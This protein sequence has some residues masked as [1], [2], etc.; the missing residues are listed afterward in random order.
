MKNEQGS[1]L[2]TVLLISL[3]FVTIGLTIATMTISSTKQ[4]EIRR[5]DASTSQQSTDEINRVIADFTDSVS[6]LSLPDMSKADYETKLQT[7]VSGLEVKYTTTGSP[8]TVLTITDVTQ[9]KLGI[10]N[11]QDYYTRYYTFRMQYV[12]NVNSAQPTITNTSTRTM[13]LSPTP[14]FLQ[15]AVGSENTL[16]LNGASDITGNIYGS[17]VTLANAARYANQLT[18]TDQTTPNYTLLETL[19]PSVVGTVVVDNEIDVYNNTTKQDG[20]PSAVLN[21]QSL[22]T[23]P[24]SQ[25]AKYFYEKSTPPLLQKSNGHF[26]TVDF[27]KT[28]ADKLNQLG[29][30]LSMTKSDIPLITATDAEIQQKRNTIVQKILATNAPTL[31]TIDSSKNRNDLFST[32]VLQGKKVV[33]LTNSSQPSGTNTYT[34]ESNL[35]LGADQWLVVDGNLELS[36]SQ[37]PLTIQGNIL[38]LGNIMIHGNTVSFS[39]TTDTMAF[40]TT[41]YA[42]GKATI[43]STN[44]VGSNNKMLVLLA[45]DDLLITRINEL[46]DATN[47]VPTMDG[48]FYTDNNAELYGVG[49]LFHIRG[50]IFAKN[51]LTINAIRQNSFGSFTSTSTAVNVPFDSRTAQIGQLSRFVVTYDKSVLVNNVN[52]LPFATKLSVISDDEGTQTKGTGQ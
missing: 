41:I 4:A 18:T 27:P 45:Q 29:I 40:A 13:L 51:E 47:S 11:P 22:S 17:K 44:I 31:Y 1:T 21:K 16:N 35:T 30:G 3:L 33:L 49:S 46:T 19:Y 20:L 7:I 24:V 8:Q 9:S 2:L 52:A 15:Y 10:S 37:S 32:G 23:T 5:I 48:Y 6:K 50:G 42:T 34:I 28:V 36:S 26:T 38:V 39:H 43:N 14:S 12:N 25:A